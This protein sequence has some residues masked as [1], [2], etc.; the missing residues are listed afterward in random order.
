M[1]WIAEVTFP[2]VA[3]IFVFAVTSRPALGP[4]QFP[5]QWA[6]GNLSLE[7]KQLQRKVKFPP[8]SSAEV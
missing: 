2:A 1:G 4:N 6:H 8:P 3:G 5:V 7:I